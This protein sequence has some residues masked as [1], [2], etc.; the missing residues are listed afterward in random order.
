MS[1]VL[2]S[3]PLLAVLLPAALLLACLCRPVRRAMPGL[4]WLAPL[5]ALAAAI[6]ARS[7][8]P[9]VLDWPPYRLAL[10]FDAPG[11]MLLGTSAL[12]W[13][14]A[15]FFC[16]GFF[17]GTPH[18]EKFAVCWLLTLTGCLGIFLAA[19]IGLFLFF[20]ALVSLPAYGMITHDGSAS[21]HRAGS[22]YIGFALVGE[23][24]LLL[25][26]VLLVANV[27]G[28]NLRIADLVA[29]LPTAPN[30]G[31]I[32]ALLIV[33][34]GMKMAL[35]PLHVWLP[36]AHAAAPMPASAV[37][38]GAVVKVGVIGM[39][40]FL[41][42]ETAL[43]AWGAGVATVGLLTAFS[44]VAIGITQS[45]PKSVLAYSSMSQMGFIATVLGMGL[46]AGDA[47][48]AKVAAFYAA[49]HVIVKGALF[50]AIGVASA[51]GRVPRF[52]LWPAA[53]I[54][55]GLAGL[56]LTGGA[57]AKLAAKGPLGYGTVAT[58]AT[59]SAAGTA[60]IMLHFLHRL[61]RVANADA[62]KSAPLGLLG[63]WLVLAI[64]AVAVPWAMLPLSG[65]G[66]VA[67]V[68]DPKALWKVLWPLL[69]GGALSVALRRWGKNLP[70]IPN[71]DI[72]ALGRAVSRP[73]LAL[74]KVTERAD[75]FVKQW[76]V[77]VVSLLVLVVLL[78]ATAI[79]GS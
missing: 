18:R 21:S 46:A 4:L 5:P 47:G 62:S 14:A 38:S 44:G 40:R 48:V 58:L 8:V 37:L 15:G 35:L 26:F 61:S 17:R 74:S 2:Q 50:L 76:P 32:L 49:H 64:A 30:R 3:L 68:L 22:A 59:W 42:F 12:L 53:L 36:L 75:D 45:N 19:D 69:V 54:A 71:G 66:S 43:A 55:L 72:A 33:G 78:V 16:A 24:V 13:S 7:T 25:A 56:P 20:Y 67:E 60:L 9:L 27:S 65:I 11:A 28:G 23:G 6:F 39:I 51:S 31:V 1:S 77:A 73:A 63:P 70:Q 57:L 10:A 52:V 41:P 29:A 34:F 79:S